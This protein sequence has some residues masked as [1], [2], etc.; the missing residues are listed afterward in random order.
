MTTNNQGNTIAGRS[1]TD[2]VIQDS[3]RHQFQTRIKVPRLKAHTRFDT[4]IEITGATPSL[5]FAVT[6]AFADF[7]HQVKES[8]ENNNFAPGGDS[9]FA[10]PSTGAQRFAIIAKEWDAAHF[11]TARKGP[12]A[13]DRTFI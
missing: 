8:D 2:V 1:I 3:S 12:I 13:T 11:E 10:A 9:R 7:D 4:T 6:G 5:G